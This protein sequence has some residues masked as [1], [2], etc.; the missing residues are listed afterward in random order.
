MTA[1]RH[2]VG[3]ARMFA[4]L[5]TVSATT[6]LTIDRLKRATD[7]SSDPVKRKTVN[8]LCRYFATIS[9]HFRCL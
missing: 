5:K 2:T 4:E 9:N 7:H 1:E 3:L 6:F 8:L